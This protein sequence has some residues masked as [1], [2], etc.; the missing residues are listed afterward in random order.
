[1]VYLKVIGNFFILAKYR[2]EKSS[3]IID[4]ETIISINE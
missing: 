1:M 3:K 2:I 4:D